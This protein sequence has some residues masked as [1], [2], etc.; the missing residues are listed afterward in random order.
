MIRVSIAAAAIAGIAACMVDMKRQKYDRLRNKN[1]T[2]RRKM[3]KMRVIKLAGQAKSPHSK[4]PN[5]TYNNPPVTNNP[6]TIAVPSF[7]V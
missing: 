2:I 6:A 1:A 3:N 4:G 7:R 5:V